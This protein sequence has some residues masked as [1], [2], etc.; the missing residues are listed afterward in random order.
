MNNH[1]RF[2]WPGIELAVN[3][4]FGAGSLATVRF[5]DETL[6]EREAGVNHTQKASS[7][8]SLLKDFD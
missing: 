3:L 4:F 1:A 8:A 2:L 5:L 6:G 7:N